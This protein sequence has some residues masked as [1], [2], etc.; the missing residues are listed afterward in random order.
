VPGYQIGELARK[1]DVPVETIRY[2][3]RAGLMP[4]PARS[5][6]NY[7][8]YSEAHA[9]QL[10]FVLNCRALDMTHDEIKTLLDLRRRPNKDCGD[11]NVIIDGHIGQV[12]RRIAELKQLLAHL[13]AL[14]TSCKRPHAVEDCRI[15]NA[16]HRTTGNRPKQAGRG[17]RAESKVA[18][19]RRSRL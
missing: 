17:R 9:A 15:L 10:A 1:F 19:A 14:R 4:E 7:R 12:T 5:D 2:Y 3:E 16:L 8:L 6:G 11:V 13:E 18:L